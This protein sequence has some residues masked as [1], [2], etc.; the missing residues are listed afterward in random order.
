MKRILLWSLVAVGIASLAM[1]PAGVAIAKEFKA[2]VGGGPTGGTFNTFANAMAVYVPK[3]LPDIKLS[4]VGS[5]GSVENVKRVS[6]GR[7]R[8]R[9]L[10]RRGHGAL[11]RKGELPKDEIKYDGT[12][13]M[14]FLYGAPAQL[15]VRADSG[16]Q[17]RQGPEGQARGRGQRR[18]RRRRQRR[19]LLPP[20]GHLGQLQAPVPG[21]LG[22]RQ[23]LQGRQDRRL[24]GAGRLSQQLDHRGLRAGRHRPDRRGHR[25]PRTAGFYNGLRLHPHDDP[26]RHLRRGHARLPDLPGRQPSCAPTTTCPRTW[27]TTS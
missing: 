17:E 11:G 25:T 21:L 7:K 6:F 13:S 23:R 26:G 24:L 4:A 22:R 2:K 5:G 16:Y 15:V 20:H 18:Q 3:V 8:L 10:L 14:G 1:T 12:R 9:S 19:A 27:S